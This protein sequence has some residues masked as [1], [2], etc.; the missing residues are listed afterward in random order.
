MIKL[1]RKAKGFT[2]IELLVVIGLIGLLAA[3]VLIAVNPARQ[4]ALGR[5]SQRSAHV[6]SILNAVGQNMAENQGNF[7][8]VSLPQ[9][10]D[11][12][13]VVAAQHISSVTG[14]T[15]LAPC[16]SPK[17]IS[18]LPRDPKTGTWA[19]AAVATPND[20]SD[21]TYDTKYAICQNS[22]TKRITVT[23][24]APEEGASISATR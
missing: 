14:E 18:D 11:C 24:V 12:T 8:C 16:I 19:D 10:A 6:N 9:A 23:A 21:D 5:N 3:V 17:Y 4:F 7:T 20:Y 15:D 1:V 2:L 13:T 22:T